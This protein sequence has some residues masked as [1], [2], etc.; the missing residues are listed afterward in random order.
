[1]Y[2]AYGLGPCDVGV[3]YGEGKWL[4]L[5]VADAEE[6]VPALEAFDFRGCRVETDF[7]PAASIAAFTAALACDPSPRRNSGDRCVR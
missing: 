5:P 6:G 3:W 2:G 4:V 7:I 1:M